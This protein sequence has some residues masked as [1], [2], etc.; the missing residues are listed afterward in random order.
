MALCLV[1]APALLLAFV[2][3]VAA[4]AGCCTVATLPAGAARA[5]SHD[6]VAGAVGTI[7]GVLTLIAI[8]SGGAGLIAMQASPTICT[9]AETY[10][11]M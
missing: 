9:V 6:V 1:L 5:V 11:I 3:V 4:V 7:A 2:A 8:V 10:R